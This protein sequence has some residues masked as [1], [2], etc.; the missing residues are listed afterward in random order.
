MAQDVGPSVSTHPVPSQA[1]ETPQASLTRIHP[2]S[3]T[4]PTMDYSSLPPELLEKMRD[5]R[6]IVLDMLN[7]MEDVR[8]Q[9]S[10]MTREINDQLVQ[11]DFIIYNAM[12]KI[13]V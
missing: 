6:E 13:S 2:Q 4:E 10:T 9:L 7:R 12:K 3:P 1:V 8:R 11:I 5:S